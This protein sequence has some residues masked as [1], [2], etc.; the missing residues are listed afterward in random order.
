MVNGFI[1]FDAVKSTETNGALVSDYLRNNVL[2]CYGERVRIQKFLDHIKARHC[3][4]SLDLE[5]DLSAAASATHTLPDGTKF[6][7]GSEAFLCAE[8]LFG[9][10]DANSLQKMVV[11]S[12]G[13]FS[14]YG[15]LTRPEDAAAERLP[16]RRQ[17]P[18][19]E[20]PRAP[21][22]RGAPPRAFAGQKPVR[23]PQ[24]HCARNRELQVR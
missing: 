20:L 2:T 17:H 3:F 24:L 14:Y 1:N 22:G 18:V 21:A 6:N 11:D 9:R 10:S 12:L 5:A 7:L 13:H 15:E 19:Q 23:L 8:R 4:V 16:G